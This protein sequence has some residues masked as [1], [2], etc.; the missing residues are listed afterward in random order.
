[1]LPP[2]LAFLS[3]S[4]RAWERIEKGRSSRFYLDLKRERKAYEQGTTA[5]TPAISLILGLR[6]S[7]KMFREEGL[8]ARFERTAI[9]AGKTREAFKSMGLELL[10]KDAPSPSLTAVVC[11]SDIDS[12]KLVKG[13]RNRFNVWIA[14]GQDHLKGRIF[15][16]SHMG[17]VTPEQLSSG[18][19]AIGSVLSEL[20]TGRSPTLASRAGDDVTLASRAG[21]DVTLA[22]RAGD[23]VTLASRAGDDEK[24][25]PT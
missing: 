25:I 9:L 15:R 20:G 21:D 19:E 24:V 18:I 3:V 2:G 6:E 5:Y 11:P 22:S 17:A 10:A 4:Q 12:G 23:D 7:L 8:A 1:M 13:V 16:V 14:G